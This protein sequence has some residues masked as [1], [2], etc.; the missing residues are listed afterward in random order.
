MLLLVSLCRT[1]L[2]FKLTTLFEEFQ[3]S[4]A[5]HVSF[6]NAFILNCYGFLVLFLQRTVLHSLKFHFQTVMFVH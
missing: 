3:L 6:G 1:W 2:Y 5:S 4:V